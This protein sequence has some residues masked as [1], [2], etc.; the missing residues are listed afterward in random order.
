MIPLSVGVVGIVSAK[1]YGLYSKPTSKHVC[2]GGGA[3]SLEE[4]FKHLI[5]NYFPQSTAISK[6]ENIRRSLSRSK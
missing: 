1:D 3:Q 4:C 5:D 2:G 6:N